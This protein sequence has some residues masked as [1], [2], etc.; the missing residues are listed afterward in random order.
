MSTIKVSIKVSILIQSATNK[1]LI[2]NQFF[3]VEFMRLEAQSLRANLIITVYFYIESN[4]LN[5][6]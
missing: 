1:K 5:K 2:M 3:V 4:A 6:R